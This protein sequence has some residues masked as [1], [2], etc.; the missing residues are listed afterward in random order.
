M[1]VPF[2][3][4]RIRAVEGFAGV[5]KLLFFHSVDPSLK[6]KRV[7]QNISVLRYADI[8]KNIYIYFNMN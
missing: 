7:A 3:F 6:T 1:G 5:H 4:G 2:G 8:C